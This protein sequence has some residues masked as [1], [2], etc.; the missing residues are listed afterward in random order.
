MRIDFTKLHALGNDFMIFEAPAGGALPT[1]AQWRAL[2]DRHTGI[3]FDQALVLEAPRAAGT[4]ST[5]QFPV[6]RPLPKT[7]VRKLVRARLDEIA[8]KQ[9]VRRR[10]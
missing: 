9:A 8:A 10:T 5:L 7:L 1:R 3:G 6:D 4:A 2:A